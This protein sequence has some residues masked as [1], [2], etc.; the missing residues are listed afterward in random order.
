M[1]YLI[2]KGSFILSSLRFEKSIVMESVS[3]SFVLYSAN[4]TII[5]KAG[6]SISGGVIRV[7]TPPLGQWPLFLCILKGDGNQWMLG[8]NRFLM[9]SIVQEHGLGMIKIIRMLPGDALFIRRTNGQWR[10]EKKLLTTP[11]P[12]AKQ[13]T[14]DLDI[15]ITQVSESLR[16]SVSAISQSKRPSILLLSGGVD[17]GLLCAFLAQQ[18]SDFEA[19][20]FK[21]PWGDEVEGAQRTANHIGVKLKIIELTADE[22]I[23]AIEKTIYWTQSNKEETILIQLLISIAFDYAKSRSKNL[24][25][26]MGSDLL[27]S[28]N[29]TGMELNKSATMASRIRTTSGLGFFHTNEL[30]HADDIIVYHPYWQAAPIFQQLAISVQLKSHDG[31]EKYY[32]RK[33]AEIHLPFENAFGIKTAIHQGSNLSSGIQEYL[34]PNTLTDIIDS[35]WMEN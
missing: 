11:T 28:V 33:L 12:L 22:I 24:I 29:E 35:I 23:S 21:T 14:L 1:P 30:T 5:N 19:I 6:L 16:S 3:T 15:A 9:K 32:L 10:W 34:S 25:T 31:F 27:N 26:G 8:N 7:M 18:Q 17:S 13:K 20:T 4:S 2:D